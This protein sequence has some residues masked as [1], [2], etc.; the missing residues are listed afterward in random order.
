[1][2]TAMIH[3][4]DPARRV[5]ERDQLLAEE[6]NAHRRPVGFE[7][8]GTRRRDPVL[9][10]QLA[11]RRARPGADDVLIWIGHGRLPPAFPR[12]SL[13][14]RGKPRQRSRGLF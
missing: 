4:P 5:A 10:H 8:S 7:L 3:H 11:H 9:P 14:S 6:E 2:G 13:A 12:Q 1:M